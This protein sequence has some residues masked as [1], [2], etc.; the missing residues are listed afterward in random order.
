MG[1]TGICLPLLH[2]FKDGDVAIDGVAEE[3]D[4]AAIVDP[5]GEGVFGETFTVTGA[6]VEPAHTRNQP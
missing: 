6:S 3:V 1:R 2:T 5:G 4:G